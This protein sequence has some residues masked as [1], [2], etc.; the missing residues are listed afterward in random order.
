M[1]SLLEQV[2]PH[3]EQR[4]YHE[5][6]LATTPERAWAALDDLRIRD[7]PMSMFL[8]R[9]RG[10]PSAWFGRVLGTDRRALDSVAPRELVA[11]PPR[12]LVLGDIACYTATRPDRPEIPRGDLAMFQSFTDPGWSKVAMNFRF[13]EDGDGTVL[14]TET[15]VQA[16]DDATRRAFRRYWLLVRAGSG[17]IRH[18]IL[19]AVRDAATKREAGQ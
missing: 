3:Y 6:R 5:T 11:D 14:S 19:R 16:T 10:G 12:E 1:S 17:L 9:L 2:L 7:L 13:L 4:E 8:T 15:R 18:D